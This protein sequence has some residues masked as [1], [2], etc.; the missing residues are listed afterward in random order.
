MQQMI[1]AI[2][3][4]IMQVLQ[5][6]WGEKKNHYC[7]PFIIENTAMTHP[8][9]FLLCVNYTLPNTCIS[10]FNKAVHDTTILQYYNIAMYMIHAGILNIEIGSVVRR[11]EICETK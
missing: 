2:K 4:T 3:T 7:Q 1:E 10:P 11:W 9:T 5:I 8:S 6:C